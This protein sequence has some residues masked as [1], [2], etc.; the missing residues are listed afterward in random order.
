M[1]RTRIA[2]SALLL[3]IGTGAFFHLIVLQKLLRAVVRYRPQ[4]PDE[5]V[6]APFAVFP[7]R[8]MRW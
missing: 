5:P 7:R 8:A 2:V 6:P 3:G 4:A 1:R